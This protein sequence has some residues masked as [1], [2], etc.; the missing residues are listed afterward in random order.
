MIDREKIKYLAKLA[1]L[2]LND[3]EIDSL[4]LDISKILS[5]VSKI[6][7]LKF[8]SELESM[9]NVIEKIELR[10]DEISMIDFSYEQIIK[11]FPEKENNYLKVPKILDKID[12]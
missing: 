10:E 6:D 5:Y 9:T 2:D 7:E 3:D 11:N 12:I 4:T 8:L 1:Y